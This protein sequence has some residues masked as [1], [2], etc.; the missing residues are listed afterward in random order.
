MLSAVVGLGFIV[1]V[2]FMAAAS[3]PSEPR[4]PRCDYC[5]RNVH[6]NASKCECCGGPRM[7]RNML[8]GDG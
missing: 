2:V 5:G 8:Y 3:S 1:F 4:P 6:P 7:P